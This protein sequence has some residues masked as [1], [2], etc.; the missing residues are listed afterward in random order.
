MKRPPTPWPRIYDLYWY[1]ASERQRIFERRTA[2]EPGPWTGV[3]PPP[4]GVGASGDNGDTTIWVTAP[5]AERMV[6]L[7]YEPLEAYVWPEH[8]RH[9]RGWYETFRDARAALL[10]GLRD[11]VPE[12]VLDQAQGACILAEQFAQALAMK[13]VGQG[14]AA[15]PA[16][17]C[18]RVG[19]H[20]PGQFR[21]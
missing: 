2:G 12:V 13:G 5:A 20:Q 17:D 9:L 4:W 14:D 8:G 1:Y 21:L 18:G 3:T 7:G 6:Q 11:A 10:D 19:S 16:P 15:F